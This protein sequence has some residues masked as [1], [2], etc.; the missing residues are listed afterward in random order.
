MAEP[1]RN[2]DYDNQETPG[3]YGNQAAARPKLSVINGGGYS[4]PPQGKLHSVAPL[5]PE[6]VK[7]GETSPNTPTDSNGTPSHNGLQLIKGG[8]GDGAGSPETSTP[9]ASEST[10]SESLSKVGMGFAKAAATGGVE[11]V[12]RQALGTIA[13]MIGNHK[14]GFA[15]GGGIS[16]AIISL[17]VVGFGF[18][19]THALLTFEADLVKFATSE[20]Q[21]FVKKA[22]Q[23][24][25]KHL[26]CR[27][28]PSTCKNANDPADPADEKD[29]GNPNDIAEQD[30]LAQEMD[31]FSF[32]SPTVSSALANQ[33]IEVKTNPD[34]SITMTD[35]TTN[36]PVTA[37]DIAN[38][39]GAIADRLQTA[40]PEWDVDQMN[41]VDLMESHAGADFGGVPVTD[42]SNTPKAIEDD[43]TEGNTGTNAIDTSVE[44]NGNNKSVPT[45]DETSQAGQLGNAIDITDRA[46][47]AGEGASQATQA[48]VDALTGASEAAHAISITGAL[49]I[50]CTLKNELV[51]AAKDRIPQII[52]LLI[53]HGAVLLSLAD[54]LK[55]GHITAKIVNSAMQMLDGNPNAKPTKAQKGTANDDTLPAT[56]SST[57]Q[58]AIENPKASLSPGMLAS[59][60]PTANAG[61]RIVMDLNN[62]FGVNIACKALTSPFGILI[63]GAIGI[64]QIAMDIGSLGAA[65][66]AIIT[67]NLAAIGTLQYVVMPQ[68]L[69]YFSL[70]GLSGAENSVQF[71]NNSGAGLTLG[72]IDQ[73]RS[74]GGMPLSP[75]QA[76]TIAGEATQEERVAEAN[77]PWTQRVLSINNPDSLVSNIALD[78]PISLSQMTSKVGS[79]FMQLPGDLMHTIGSI[80]SGRFVFALT[81]NQDPGSFYS[82]TEY[83]FTDGQVDQYDPVANE[84]YLYTDIPGSNPAVTRIAALGNPSNDTYSSSAGEEVDSSGSPVTNDLLHCFIDGY[85][86]LQEGSTPNID[87]NCGDMGNY[88]AT[89]PPASLP[90]NQTVIQIY[91]QYSSDNSDITQTVNKNDDFN[92]FRQYILDTDIMNNYMELTK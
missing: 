3:I 92:R 43:I 10:E 75:A 56:A 4:T 62:I 49:T 9:K 65:Q 34:G 37:D 83:G 41:F 44:P 21:H 19:A 72:S 64:G 54:Q 1:A 5:S 42:E 15:I 58:A 29:S 53:R 25:M 51:T 23:S 68:A 52:S 81:T 32:D 47:A 79:Y 24:L 18:I 60:L 82:A 14:R 88:D 38:N 63:Q 70:A 89:T 20:E 48:G 71:M 39:S 73:S 12:A 11:G 40:L 76:A 16:G 66:V 86:Q 69:Q 85:T 90:N 36:T 17:V 26:A 31:T 30:P 84:Q 46:L 35:T 80:F 6:E 28:M 77:L 8:K 74:L 45:P 78:M 33:G 13:G 67:A 91:G 27:V 61:T 50:A 87:N 55:S 2:F 59:A 22:D 57:W 7:A